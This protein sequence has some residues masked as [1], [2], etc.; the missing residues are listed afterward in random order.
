MEVWGVF[1]VAV[2]ATVELDLFEPA[3]KQE[4][5]AGANALV[6]EVAFGGVGLAEGGSPVS[7]AREAGG[8]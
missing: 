5:V 6:A 7:L 1:D 8:V 4:E 2:F 3:E